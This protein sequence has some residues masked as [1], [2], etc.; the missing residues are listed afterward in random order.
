M[1]ALSSAT[2]SRAAGADL[3]ASGLTAAAASGGDTFPAGP[4]TY[5]RVKNTKG[6]AVTVTVTPPTGSGPSGTT[7]APLALAPPVP[8]TTGDR[9]YGPFPGNPFA[10]SSGNV[11]VS[12]SPAPVSGDVMAEVLVM[13]AS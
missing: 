9:L 7:V 4:S 12:Y 13:A 2:P 3:S 5:L 8:A 6:S 11:N 1:A 10:D